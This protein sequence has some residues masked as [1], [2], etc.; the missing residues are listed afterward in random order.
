MNKKLFLLLPTLLL[1]SCGMIKFSKD[2]HEEGFEGGPINNTKVV[3][4]YDGDTLDLQGRTSHLISFLPNLENS[5]PELKTSDAI[6]NVMVDNDNVVSGFDNIKNVNQFHGL[7]IGHLT[8]SIDGELKINL[9][10]NAVAAKLMVRPRA[11][12][13]TSGGLEEITIDTNV[14]ISVN[15]SKYIKVKND[16][17]TMEAIEDTICNYSLLKD[18]AGVNELD[19]S[20]VYQRVEI[21]SITLYE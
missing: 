7:K 12:V 3:E 14:A 11:N 19:L 8:E 10:I 18:D 17:T 13:V 9:N 20:V 16:F 5:Q 2:P 21:M 6:K 15:D 4:Y 1:T